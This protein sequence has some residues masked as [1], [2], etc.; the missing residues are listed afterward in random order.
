MKGDQ[1]KAIKIS[2][3]KIIRNSNYCCRNHTPIKLVYNYS[4]FTKE[5]RAQLWIGLAPG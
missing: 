3:K 2:I 5:G 1:G 4:S